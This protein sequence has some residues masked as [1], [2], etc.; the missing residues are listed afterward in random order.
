MDIIKSILSSSCQSSGLVFLC[1][2]FTSSAHV[3]LLHIFAYSFFW[4]T[5]RENPFIL[6]SEAFMPCA[7]IIL[8]NPSCSMTSSKNRCKNNEGIIMKWNHSKTASRQVDFF[9]ALQILKT[10]LSLYL[11]QMLIFNLDFYFEVA[12]Y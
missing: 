1:I 5:S 4:H 3:T 2:V 9:R 10:R 11:W 7:T 12:S 8:Q 6:T